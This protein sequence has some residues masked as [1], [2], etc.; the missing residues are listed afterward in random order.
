MI[1]SK[2]NEILIKNQIATQENNQ[3]TENKFLDVLIDNKNNNS[4]KIELTYQ[5]IRNIPFSQIDTLFENSDE[6]TMARN[7][8][9]ATMFSQ[10]ENLSKAL[11]NTVLGKPFDLGYTYLYNMYEDKSNYLNST[12]NNLVTLLEQT[13]NKNFE[14]EEM[15]V[16]DKISQSK[17]NEILTAV[18]SYNFVTALTNG[19]K[20]LNDK[21]K[22]SD[23]KY[24]FLY[25][26]FYLQYQE[27]EYKYNKIKDEND[28]ILNQL[29]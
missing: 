23:N 24:S 27:L 14:N 9:L 7:L 3:N 11:F 26:D 25:N 16:T 15:K 19:Y 22:D 28:S 21:Y 13:I 20:D 2:I 6:K 1:T 8:K 29:R 18:N 4:S 10:D 17:L 12:T 5:N